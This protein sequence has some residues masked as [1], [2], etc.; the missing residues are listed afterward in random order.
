MNYDLSRLGIDTLNAMQQEVVAQC[1]RHPNV[2]LLSPT[3]SG[4]TLAYLLPLATQVDEECNELQALVLVPTRE[5][6]VQTHDTLCR[7][8]PQCRCMA[9]YGGRAAMDEHRTLRSLRPQVVIATP[10]RMLDHL[11]KQ[12]LLPQGVKMLVIDEFDKSLEMGFRQQMSDILSQLT[13]LER[14]MLLSATDSADIPQ[15]V[16]QNQFCRIDYSV[17]P[18]EDAD[19]ISLYEVH[20][21]HKDKL[22]TLLFLIRTLGDTTSIVFVNYR[23]SAD[24]VGKFLKDNGVS[25]AVYHGQMEQRQRER[26]LYR[27]AN[28]SCRVLVSTDLA[29]RGLDIDSIDNIIHYHLPLDDKAYIHR[30]GRTARWDAQ[31]N[32]YMILGPEEHRP[33]YVPAEPQ[34]FSFPDRIPAPLPPR[35]ATLYIGKGKQDKVNRV[36]V[37]GFLSKIGGLSREEL[38]R[39]DVLPG[40]A[41]A[42]VAR[43]AVPALLKRI[44]G[45]K[46]KGQKTIF[47]LAD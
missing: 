42:A 35:W 18:H 29:A 14:T 34:L 47:A 19:R 1:R 28:G 25:T 9:C 37:V 38:G 3:G 33:A 22:T 10:G 16:G 43:Q 6:A 46:I 4:K 20:S 8:C 40:W 12:N 44:N 15:F 27:F 39:V 23:E 5:L 13:S 2:V 7:L 45:H 36:D 31:G 21:P 11:Q 26:T 41:Y 17:A 32:S 30:N 24:R